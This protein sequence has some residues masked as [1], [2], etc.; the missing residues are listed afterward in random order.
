MASENSLQQ[1]FD[2]AKRE[3][4]RELPSRISFR[5]LLRVTTIDEVYDAARE[6][7]D[8]QVKTSGG[9]RNL[10]RIQPLLDRLNEFAGVIEVFVQVQPDILALIWGPIKLLI[11]LVS[12]WTQGYDAVV[13]MMERIGELLPC[14]S[15]V[16]IH[17]LDIER[18]KDILGL[19]FRDI[20]DFFLAMFQFFSLPR[21]FALRTPLPLPLPLPLNCTRER[22]HARYYAH[23][24]R[25]VKDAKSYLRLSGQSIERESRSLKQ[26]SSGTRAYWGTI[27][28]MNT[29]EENT[30][31]ARRRLNTLERR[32]HLGPPSASEPWKR[33]YVPQH[34][35][36]DS[37]GCATNSAM[38]R[39]D[40]SRRTICF[41]PGLICRRPRKSRSGCA[42]FLGQ[43][44]ATRTVPKPSADPSAKEKP[45]SPVG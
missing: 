19:F 4:E 41:A 10:Q 37:M 34:M 39:Q 36:L 28:P 23:N 27:L 1:I 30:R 16:V 42:V 25:I 9:I 3:F 14:F 35:A 44:S 33:R 32:K 18:I 13:K 11:Q 45:S 38:E 22:C 15:D 24:N 40:G 17:F 43:V 2:K 20:L 26:T 31:H 7:Q 6:Y 8:E 29:S 5:S 12:G 21:T